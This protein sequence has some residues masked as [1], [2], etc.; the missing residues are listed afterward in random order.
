MPKNFW[1]HL[2]P[3]ILAVLD[4][5]YKISTPI[6]II[7]AASNIISSSTRY[8]KSSFKPP[9]NSS[10]FFASCIS[11]F[12]G[13]LFNGRENPGGSDGLGEKIQLALDSFCKELKIL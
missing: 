11:N 10:C 7:F 3:D 12:E 6:L 1:S 5:R 9:L 4:T 13:F 2:K 8:V